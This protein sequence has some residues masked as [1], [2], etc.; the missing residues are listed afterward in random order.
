[1]SLKNQATYRGVD[2]NDMSKEEL[3]EALTEM[4]N[5]YQGQLKEHSRQ[6][7][8]LKNIEVPFNEL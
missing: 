5:L 1:M 3:I 6:L 7:D 2:L 4:S 8:F